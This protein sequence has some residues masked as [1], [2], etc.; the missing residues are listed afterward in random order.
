MKHTMY[1]DGQTITHKITAI[2][3]QPSKVAAEY[4]IPG[5]QIKGIAYGGFQNNKDF[6]FQTAASLAIE[7][8]VSRMEAAI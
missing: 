3:S 8:A 5:T 2:G 1:R 7:N 6:D 4:C